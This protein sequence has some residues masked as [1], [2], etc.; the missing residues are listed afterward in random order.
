MYL[1][2]NNDGS[3]K[4]SLFKDFVIQGSDNVNFIYVAIED[5]NVEQWT[6]DAS[7][8]LPDNE[9]TLT[10]AGSVDNF[11]I[12][13]HPYTGYKIPLTQS[14]T[15]QSGNM[16]VSVRIYSTGNQ[17]LYTYPATIVVNESTI[18]WDADISYA[19]YRS[20][21]AQLS[22]YQ[23]AFVNSNVRGY[24]STAMAIADLS[25]LAANQIVV[26]YDTLS[27]V[28]RFFWKQS[29]N[30][31]ELKGLGDVEITADS[32]TNAIQSI[33]NHQGTFYP[34]KINSFYYASSNE[35]S[36]STS[37]LSGLDLIYNT[38]YLYYNTYNN[39]LYYYNGSNALILLG[40]LQNLF[41]LEYDEQSD[42]Y[43]LTYAKAVG[44]L[45]ALESIAT[46][47]ILFK[48]SGGDYDGRRY[49]MNYNYNSI[50]SKYDL[51][52]VDFDID[53]STHRITKAE[54]FSIE[55]PSTLPVGV[56][57]LGLWIEATV[58]VATS[59]N[60]TTFNIG[61]TQYT[62]PTNNNQLSNGAGYLTS[63]SSEIISMQSDITGLGTN[64]QD[65]L[66]PGTNITISNNVISATDTN[67][68]YTITGSI[69]S[70]VLTITL[71]DDGGTTQSATV[72]L[73]TD[74]VVVSGVYDS[75]T[76][77]II[78][79]LNNG[80]TI[81]IPV[82]DL[83]SGLETTID[84]AASTIAHTDLTANKALISNSSGKVAV[85]GVSDTELGYL[86]G[87]S[88]AIQ[89][90]LNGKQAALTAGT[91]ITIS[92][93]TISA[94]DTTYSKATA[95]TFGLVKVNG[96]A[97]SVASNNLSATTGRTY[98]VQFDSNDNLV[99]NVPWTDT[100]YAIENAVS[101]G[102]TASLV[103]TGEKYNWNNKQNALTPTSV[104][105]GTLAEV[106][107]FD[108]SNNL[109]RGVVAS[110]GKNNIN[111]VNALPSVSS[112]EE[113]ILYKLNNDLYALT[114]TEQIAPTLSYD[115]S[116]NTLTATVDYDASYIDVYDSSDTLLFT[117]T[118]S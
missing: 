5:R 19:N 95:S 112:A 41:E 84:G 52:C 42:G 46:N 73:P 26:A 22:A 99:V 24:A 102:T 108:S 64:K 45:S 65:K 61:G 15:S 92:G 43:E 117:I 74:Q 80:N 106:I 40:A 21:L 69:S 103:S 66:T 114:E 39:E 57:Y 48:F 60:A 105:S 93:N 68:T 50:A 109:V 9:T 47:F 14:I 63:A 34:A 29:G 17:L 10:S 111:I 35:K 6:C 94:T 20:Y 88:S 98:A 56:G 37:A 70:G 87:V 16:S 97:Q 78:L 113:D 85:S 51:V 18:S 53:G 67:T 118:L 75:T 28:Y 54:K 2:Y 36:I 49:L 32:G 89:T 59:V 71:T 44:L 30:L 77:S 55:I 110:S 96:T 115:S 76:Q 107:G 72:N 82:G 7:F 1:I 12:D 81:T 101:G 38:N 100:T 31:V 91:N 33:K 104:N 13:G 58:D 4:F 90:Q 79:T 23:L 27:N 11:T 83:V 116:T 86:S 62:I 25:N 8:L 3:I